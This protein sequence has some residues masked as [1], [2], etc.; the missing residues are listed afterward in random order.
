[1]DDFGQLLD[2]MTEAIRSFGAEFTTVW[3][4][5][6]IALILLAAAIGYGLSALVRRHIDL[7]ALLTGWPPIVRQMVIAIFQNLAFIIFALSTATMHAGL[8]QVTT[9][10]RSYLLHIATSLATHC[11]ETISSTGLSPS[12][13]GPSRH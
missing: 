13:P 8:L 12:R 4:P 2:T 9:P 10:A 3:F 5:V 11:C 7:K 1:M 6:Q